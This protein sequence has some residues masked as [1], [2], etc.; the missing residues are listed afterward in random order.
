MNSTGQEGNERQVCGANGAKKE[1]LTHPEGV[2]R[3]GC[4]KKGFMEEVMSQLR[5][6]GGTGDG[7]V[8]VRKK[9]GRRKRTYG[10]TE[11]R[12]RELVHL[13]NCKSF[14]MAGVW[15]MWKN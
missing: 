3:G 1:H 5:P 2:G 4:I 14:S 15:C 12:E 7:W 11:E 13:G 6:S 8:M 10:S 9:V